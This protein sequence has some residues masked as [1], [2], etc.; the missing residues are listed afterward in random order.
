MAE[1]NLLRKELREARKEVGD[2]F[3]IQDAFNALEDKVKEI[4]DERDDLTHSSSQVRLELRETKKELVAQKKLYLELENMVDV[5]KTAE[6]KRAE[7]KEQR[8][9]ELALAEVKVRQEEAKVTASAS[10]VEY[11]KEA[12][13][14]E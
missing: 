14:K 4:R 7:M 2:Y 12:R 5:A 6:S 3:K 1:N 10:A 13:K 9:H 8:A 11:K